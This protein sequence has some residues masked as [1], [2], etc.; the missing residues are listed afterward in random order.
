MSKLAAALV[1]TVVVFFL[2]L[3]W[4]PSGFA[5]LINW[6][7][8]QL[9]V[10]FQVMLALIFFLFGNP[11]TYTVIFAGWA[12]AG[13]IIGLFARGLR[14][15][16]SV[17]PIVFSMT[18]ALLGLSFLGVFINLDNSGLI[19]GNLP[20]V[21]PGTTISSLLNAPV[22]SQFAPLFLSGVSGT[23]GSSP[24][25]SLNTSDLISSI[26]P[27]LIGSAVILFAF[28][29]GV[30]FFMGRLTKTLKPRAKQVKETAP[31]VPVTV[32]TAAIVILAILV[33]SSGFLFFP[34]SAQSS[35]FSENGQN[36]TGNFQLGT[37]NNQGTGSVQIA[38]FDSGTIG[39]TV[40]PNWVGSDYV[41][42]FVVNEFKAVPN[43][44]SINNENPYG[45]SRG[46][47]LGVFIYDINCTDA[48]KSEAASAAAAFNSGLELLDPSGIGG[49]G[50]GNLSYLAS[51]PQNSW[52]AVIY[53]SSSNE[54]PTSLLENVPV[55]V[56]TSGISESSANIVFNEATLVA[57]NDITSTNWQAFGY[58]KA[59]YL[60]DFPIFGLF[61]AA[62]APKIAQDYPVSFGY[63]FATIPNL[64]HSSS[65]LHNVSL[66]TLMG[67]NATVKLGGNFSASMLGVPQPSFNGTST[68][69]SQIN[70]LLTQFGVD[71]SAVPFLASASGFS[72]SD[73]NWTAVTT[74]A[75]LLAQVIGAGQ[76]I[77][78]LNPGG[79]INASAIHAVFNRL[80][81][82]YLVVTKTLTKQSDGSL[83]VKVSVQNRD[84]DSLTNLVLNDSGFTNAYSSS[85][86]VVSGNPYNNSISSLG[87]YQTQNYS[88]VV[89]PSGIG[90][91]VST[92]AIITYKLN[93]TQF[94]TFSNA[95]YYNSTTSA[96]AGFEALAGS[97]G[98]V[99]GHY[100]GLGSSGTYVIYAILVVLFVAAGFMEYRGFNKW[101]KG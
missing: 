66:A 70:S 89:K 29:L 25:A 6:L 8:P 78:N 63:L 50:V 48:V 88:Y 80:L 95:A 35:G 61:A 12:I 36:F 55:S 26:L 75:T 62:S 74:N 45:Y 97:A 31:V 49:N 64:V 71:P 79:S 94:A 101:R 7:G 93:G 10:S 43:T 60:K 30:G 86:Q 99:L 33:F 82:A 87:E 39:N 57:S 1:S 41:A 27:S 81:P 91:Y 2:A 42:A 59:Q 23:G 38:Q 72:F 56:G 21:P 46:P 54:D 14:P 24:L 98:S 58:I 34:S 16:L 90:T 68:S 17:A 11:I 92:P 76:N 53:S 20:P 47:T 37:F 83:L 13:V 65:N 100:A 15:A 73:Y 9:G 18:Y 3:A 77:I 52:C 51:I 5:P 84:N 67:S 4:I 44:P 96:T 69:N 28:S 32:K 40:N 22:F 19:H 85:M